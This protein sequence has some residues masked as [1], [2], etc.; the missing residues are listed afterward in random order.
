MLA[1]E[2]DL[3]IPS[4][5]SGQGAPSLWLMAAIALALFAAA[6]VFYCWL[7]RRTGEQDPKKT[8]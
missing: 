6:V 7:L 2:R 5:L 3:L 1:E 4:P 8:G